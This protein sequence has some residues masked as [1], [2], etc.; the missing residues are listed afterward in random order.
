MGKKIPLLVDTHDMAYEI[1]KLTKK[2]TNREAE[3]HRKQ[4]EFPGQ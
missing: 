2:S 4:A 3:F 1:T